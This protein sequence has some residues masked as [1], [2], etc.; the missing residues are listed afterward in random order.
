MQGHVMPSFPHTLIGLGP[1]ANLG[2]Q[3][4]F[5]KTA[6]S[7]IHP[8]GHTILEGWRE[9]DSP[10]LW[11]FPLQATKSSLLA[12]A[13]FDKYEEPGQCG[14]AA[15]FLP[16]PPVIPI[17]CPPVAPMP[18]LRKPSPMASTA[19][20]HS[21]Q[22]FSAVY[23]AGQAF[24]VSYQYGSAQALALAA[25]STTTSFDPCSLNLPSVGVLVGSYHACLGFPVKQTW[26]DAI[27]AGN[28]D[29][30]D[31]LTYANAAR[32]FPDA[33]E[34][35]MGHLAQQC[36][37]V[38][39]T[40]PK[41]HAHN[42]APLTPA[43]APLSSALPSNEVYIHVYPISKL[44]MDDM[45]Q[46]P[47][48]ACSGNQYV[49]IAYHTDCN[50]ILQQA[51]KSKSDPHRIVAYNAIM[52]RLAARGVSVD[53]QILDNKASAAYKHAITFTWQAKFQLVPPDMHCRNHAERAIRTFKAHFLSILAGVDPT[54]PPYLWDLLL[55]QA[56][57]TLN[58]L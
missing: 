12:T 32:Y 56:E 39:S 28:C 42:Q 48:K 33:D 10:H 53:L 26:L 38:W 47:F 55:P 30:F 51:F 35:I 15:D 58:L 6:V 19:P 11:S 54:F 22:G 37:N 4:L 25:R 34:A 16:A 21:S 3:I 8:D 18:P 23:D 1:F 41:P 13:L 20:L 5:T 29:L 36:Q 40:K 14:S 46:F 43:I 45:G 50:L 17:Q 52:M 31:G 9:V 2:C 44:Y 49:M 57:L 7:V 27:K 24:F